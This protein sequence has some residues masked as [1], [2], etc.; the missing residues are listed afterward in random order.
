MAFACSIIGTSMVVLMA[1]G[2]P[3]A[4]LTSPTLITPYCSHFGSFMSTHSSSSNYTGMIFGL[5]PSLTSMRSSLRPVGAEMAV[6][7]IYYIEMTLTLLLSMLLLQDYR[8]KESEKARRLVSPLVTLSS[9]N[10]PTRLEIHPLRLQSLLREQDPNLPEVKST[11]NLSP[12]LSHSHALISLYNT[13]LAALP[14]CDCRVNSQRSLWSK[15]FST[16][17]P[18]FHSSV[19]SKAPCTPFLYITGL[20][21]FYNT[22]VLLLNVNEKP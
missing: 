7:L 1:S 20:S 11:Q 18:A 14:I 13:F 8:S 22:A 4:S 17:I 15:Q 6:A 16:I 3:L 21:L 9:E 5:R 19:N 10:P 12:F 2:G